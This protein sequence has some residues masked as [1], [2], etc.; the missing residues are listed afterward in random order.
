M[1]SLDS[2]TFQ[3]YE[4][5]ESHTIQSGVTLIGHWNTEIARVPLR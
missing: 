5:Y 1:F 4:V 3:K 2:I